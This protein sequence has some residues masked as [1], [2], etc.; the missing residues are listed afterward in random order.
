MYLG[1]GWMNSPII[2]LQSS[3]ALLDPRLGVFWFISFVHLCG[4]GCTLA[5]LWEGSGLQGCRLNVS[6]AV[7][8]EEVV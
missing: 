4:F 1:Q 8:L 2:S 3:W 5:G 7:F 6:H